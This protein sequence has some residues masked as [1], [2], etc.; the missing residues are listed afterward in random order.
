[1]PEEK[2]RRKLGVY[3]DKSHIETVRKLAE[4][5]DNGCTDEEIAAAIGCSMKTVHRWV[6]R[7]PEFAEARNST[8]IIKI[9][10]VEES[11]FKSA[12]GYETEEV[13]E[14]YDEDNNLVRKEVTKKQ[15]P[16][17][18]TAQ[19][20]YL[21]NCMPVKWR[22]KQDIQHTGEIDHTVIVLPANQRIK[23]I[24]NGIK[25]LEG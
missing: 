20:F 21:K 11:L 25:E 7:Y 24:P 4:Q 17:N 6:K 8:K 13:K 9:E 12:R 2:K 18:T 19:I 1:M 14:I 3:W 16:P 15:V 23:E 22:D 10:Q 5:S